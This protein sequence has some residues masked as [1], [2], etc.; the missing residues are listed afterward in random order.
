MEEKTLHSIKFLFQ[1]LLFYWEKKFIILNAK[2]CWSTLE[3]CGPFFLLRIYKVKTLLPFFLWT[4]FGT[5][6][7][8]NSLGDRKNDGWK[9]QTNFV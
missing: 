9:K 6:L 4:K 7:F 8:Y 3:M 5:I 2:H 1:L